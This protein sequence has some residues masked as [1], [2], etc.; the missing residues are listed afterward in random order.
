MG[1]GRDAKIAMSHQIAELVKSGDICAAFEFLTNSTATNYEEFSS[2]G[3]YQTVLVALASYEPLEATTQADK[4][5]K[6]IVDSGYHPTSEVVNAIVAIW[7]KS[8]RENSADRCMQYIRSLWSKHD[9]TGDEQFVPMRSSYVSAIASLS[10]GRS[11]IGRENA[12][13]AEAL[14]EEMEKRR[15]SHPRLSLNTVT[16]NA[17]L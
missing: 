8:G 12:E 13:Q 14:L 1:G 16:V 9:Q 3:L 2:T 17:V 15:V 11:R 5:Y 4:L 10:R 7:A 6:T